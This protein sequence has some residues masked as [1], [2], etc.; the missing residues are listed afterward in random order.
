[1]VHARTVCSQA[2]ALG[3]RLERVTRNYIAQER[4]LSHLAGGAAEALRRERK[5]FERLKQ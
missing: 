1:M 3:H 2:V 5:K 4:K